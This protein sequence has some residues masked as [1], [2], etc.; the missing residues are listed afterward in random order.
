MRELTKRG[1]NVQ[2][3]VRM[4]VEYDDVDIDVGYR[5]DLLVED[6]VVVEL[7]AVS[8]L[9]PIHEAQLL[10]YLKLSGRRVGLL[11]N[12]NVLRLK[13]GIKRMIND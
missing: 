4:P 13:D 3:Q 10:T 12:F 6:Q 1:V 5:I 2:S 7:K 9:A 8:A 11:I